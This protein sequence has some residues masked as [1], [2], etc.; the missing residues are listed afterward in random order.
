MKTTGKPPTPTKSEDAT[1]T[2]E[3]TYSP[4]AAST[5]HEQGNEDSPISI[6]GSQPGDVK[7]GHAADHNL[8]SDHEKEQ[9]EAGISGDFTID[10]NL[11]RR[12]RR[13]LR[14]STESQGLAHGQEKDWLHRLREDAVARRVPPPTPTSA[15]VLP[16][17]SSPKSRK[18]VSKLV[19]SPRKSPR[20][21]GNKTTTG[22]S[23]KES[24]TNEA[25]IRASE[26]LT[27]L[28]TKKTTPQ[29][30]L[31]KLNANGKL[32]SSPTTVNRVTKSKGKK[33]GEKHDNQQKTNRIVLKYGNDQEGRVRIGMKIDEVMSTTSASRKARLTLNNAP[34]KATHPFFLGKHTQ[35]VEP[36]ARAGSTDTLG[37]DEVSAVEDN[38]S[39]LRTTV[40]WK[41]I[42]F[43]SRKPTFTKTADT[44][45]APWPPIEMQHLG[46]E[47]KERPP[48][49]TLK[50]RGAASS[51]S[52]ERRTQIKT[53]EDVM[54]CKSTTILHLDLCLNFTQAS[55]T[56]FNPK[57][58][59]QRIAFVYLNA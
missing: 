54:H 27:T 3:E 26:P 2:T 51:K 20:R 48:S 40:P 13:K 5:P 15:A 31:L 39:S 37:K 56:F 24:I 19:A 1:S 42:V 41:D 47:V 7:P 18:T 50:L 36:T 35:T 17:S 29:K 21:T 33:E 44:T 57:R 4:G 30:K 59:R 32:L 52:K 6:P 12:K 25:A 8:A 43:T 58:N 22:S 11:D 46:A 53:E 9:V 55:Q 23:S 16:P 49:H 38:P 10:L 14:P 45:G 28:P 34:P